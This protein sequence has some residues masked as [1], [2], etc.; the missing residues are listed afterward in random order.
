MIVF[1]AISYFYIFICF[2]F[3]LVGVHSDTIFDFA[4]AEPQM[5]LVTACGDK[6]SKLCVLQTSGGLDQAQEFIHDSP[7]KSVMFRPGSSGKCLMLFCYVFK[8]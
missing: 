6:T 1:V 4:W 8:I 7:V 3:K 2:L 5:K